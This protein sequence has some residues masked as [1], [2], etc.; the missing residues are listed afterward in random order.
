MWG[1]TKNK[2]IICQLNPV[3]LFLSFTSTPFKSNTCTRWITHLKESF[4]TF[5]SFNTFLSCPHPSQPYCPSVS[6]SLSASPYRP[7]SR[8][9]VQGGVSSTHTQAD[10]YKHLM[11]DSCCSP[12][13]PLPEPAAKASR[14]F[15]SVPVVAASSN[16]EANIACHPCESQSRQSQ[17]ATGVAIFPIFMFTTVSTPSK[18]PLCAWDLLLQSYC[19]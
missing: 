5:L 18:R 4:C 2:C 15:P 8:K 7:L 13:F 16:W 3:L 12:A 17:Q 6:S 19:K 14:T 9:Q 1:D 11:C 10:T